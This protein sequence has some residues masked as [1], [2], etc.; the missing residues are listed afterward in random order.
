[1]I[2]YRFPTNVSLTEVVQEYT[3]QRDKL[4]GNK[5]LPM[6]PR[7]TQFIEWDELDYEAGM[8]APHN[9]NVDPRVSGRPGQK[10]HRFA[11]LFFKET[12]VLK[13]SDMLMPRMAGTLGGV[14]DLSA[15]IARISKARVDKNFLRLEW[16]IWQTLKGH[17]QY[18]ENGVRVD[19]TF[20]V[21]TQNALVDWDEFA[22][23]T[24]IKDFQVMALRGRGLGVSFKAGATAYMNQ[25]TANWAVN[26]RNDN[27]LWGYRNRDS[28]NATYSISDVN[29]ILVAQSCP[30]IEVHDE[31]YYDSD[32]NFKL[33]L[34]DGE[35]VVVGKRAAGETV[36]DVILTPSLHDAAM[37]AAGGG[38]AQHG[39]FSII[40][41][42]GQ[43][44]PGV[45]TIA[46][47]GGHKNPKVEIT[48]GFYGGPR[49]LY[50]KSVINFNAKVT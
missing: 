32:G 30:T 12:D 1:M 44:N 10:T 9:M 3:I 11:P 16:L 17:L 35:V 8:T 6:R 49:L 38:G 29:K 42:N 26:N 23:A 4:V 46:E 19:E 5:L 21:Q 41:V 28:V 13:E 2:T 36:G 31:G 27:D 25:T 50:P 22:T 40:E 48:G 14:L 45:V 18:N 20:G 37:A 43:A 33:S 7:D 15:E 34:A 24:I 39:F 47:L